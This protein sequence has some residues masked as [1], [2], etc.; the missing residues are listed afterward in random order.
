MSLTCDKCGHDGWYPELRLL[1][2]LTLG[3]E[4]LVSRDASRAKAQIEVGENAVN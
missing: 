1:Y 3:R 2:L 4:H